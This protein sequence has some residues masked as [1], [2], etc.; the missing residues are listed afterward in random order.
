MAM[1]LIAANGCHLSN[2]TEFRLWD[3]VDEGLLC[4]AASSMQLEW[5]VLPV[6]HREPSP[7]E[8]YV[9]SFVKFH[10]HRLGSPLSCFMRA[11]LN[12]YGVKLQHLSPNAIS[13]VVIFAAVCEGYLGVMPH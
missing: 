7:P 3:L 4:P 11:L 13:N 2:M 10:R 8:G 5:I 12:H 6:E 1:M 9:V